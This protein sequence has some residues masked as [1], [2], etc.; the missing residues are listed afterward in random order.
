MSLILGLGS[1]LGNRI[2]NIE[3]AIEKLSEHFEFVSKASLYTSAAVDYL[4][5]PDFINT[6]AEFK[7]PS[8]NPSEVIQ[9]ILKI[10]QDMGRRRDIP[11]GPRTIDIDILFWDLET[12]NLDNLQ[13]PHPSW[14]DR[15]F[16]VRPLQELPYFQTLKNHFI[17]P[18]DFNNSCDRL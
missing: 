17:I 9:L 11:K 13:V 18:K 10:E 7:T 4:N 1:N 15:S 6:T 8:K 5:Q 12:I 3:N 2:Q 16:V 14:Q